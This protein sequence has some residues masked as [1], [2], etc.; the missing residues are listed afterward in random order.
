MLLLADGQERM[1]KSVSYTCPMKEYFSGRR[2][3]LPASSM[4]AWL[5][6]DMF[7]LVILMYVAVE[8]VIF[9]TPKDNVSIVTKTDKSMSTKLQFN[10]SCFGEV[11]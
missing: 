5:G 10:A 11:N 9:K 7:E 2:Y 6:P 4:Y 3:I 8:H 1:A